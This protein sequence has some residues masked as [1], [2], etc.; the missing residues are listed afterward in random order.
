MPTKLLETTSPA[1]MRRMVRAVNAERDRL[2]SVYYHE[3]RVLGIRFSFRRLQVRLS[4]VGRWYDVSG[5][6]VDHF[7][8][9][10]GQP[11]VASR[12]VRQ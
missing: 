5:E 11:F 9:G 7:T 12:E 10:N 4:S 2:R 3:K 6:Q 8:D 1:Y